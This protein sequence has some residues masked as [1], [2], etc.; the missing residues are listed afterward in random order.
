MGSGHSRDRALPRTPAIL[1]ET[2][3]TPPP[4]AYCF[5]ERVMGTCGAL[6]FDQ[7]THQASEW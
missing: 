1:K 2:F 7:A 6:S 3:L 5:S 4:S